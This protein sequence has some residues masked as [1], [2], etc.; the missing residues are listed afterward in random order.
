MIWSNNKNFL[1]LKNTNKLTARLR[2][3]R[4][5][6]DNVDDNP[7]SAT[8]FVQVTKAR[9]G[10]RTWV[11][12]RFKLITGDWKNKLKQAKQDDAIIKLRCK[13]GKYVS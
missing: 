4:S 12:R 1:M 13:S 11:C 9:K 3:I 10:R 7:G 6:E 2:C 8:Y 5:M